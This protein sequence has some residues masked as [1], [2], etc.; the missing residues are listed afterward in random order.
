MTGCTGPRSGRDCHRRASPR[1]G[2]DEQEGVRTYGL[3]GHPHLRHRDG[4]RNRVGAM[5]QHAGS[6]RRRSAPST[7]SPCSP[8]ASRSDTTAAATAW[9]ATMGAPP[10][11]GSALP[12]AD[13]L[14]NTCRTGCDSPTTVAMNGRLR[15]RSASATH[16]R[17]QQR[18]D[19]DVR[20]RKSEI[21][22]GQRV[23]GRG[24]HEEPAASSRPRRIRAVPRPGVSTTAS[25]GSAGRRD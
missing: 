7:Q 5:R 8:P 9:A 15:R 1:V 3:R 17:G 11:Q 6:S 2:A 4:C 19:D 10:C 23:R 16:M 22:A 18:G 25:L 14:S 24:D 20:A 13:R 12:C 21:S